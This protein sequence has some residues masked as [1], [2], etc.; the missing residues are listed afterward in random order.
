MADQWGGKRKREK[1]PMIE[2]SEAL[3]FQNISTLV[4]AMESEAWGQTSKSQK[5]EDTLESLDL[6]ASSSAIEVYQAPSLAIVPA[7]NFKFTFKELGVLSRDEVLHFVDTSRVKDDGIVTINSAMFSRGAVEGAKEYPINISV[8]GLRKLVDFPTVGECHQIVKPS[9]IE[10]AFF[11]HCGQKHKKEAWKVIAPWFS[12]NV[13][14]AQPRSEGWVVD[15]FRKF[16]LENHPHGSVLDMKVRLVIRQVLRTLGKL[17]QQYCSTTLVLLA[18]AHIDPTCAHLRPDW[19]MFVSSEIRESLNHEKIDRKSVGKFREGWAAI[20]DLVRNEFMTKQAAQSNQPLYLEAK[21]AFSD[22]KAEWD[23]EKCELVRQREE[24]KEELAKA[25]ELKAQLVDE[26]SQLHEDMKKVSTKEEQAELLQIRSQMEDSAKNTGETTEL[27][28]ELEAEEE[29]LRK[30]QEADKKIRQKLKTAKRKGKELE[31]EL[32]K[33]PA[34]VLVKPESKVMDLLKSGKK[35][36]LSYGCSQTLPTAWI[37]EFCLDREVDFDAL[38]ERYMCSWDIRSLPPNSELY[39]TEQDM[40]QITGV[41]QM[42]AQKTKWQH[43]LGKALDAKTLQS[44][45]PGKSSVRLWLFGPRHRV[46]GTQFRLWSAKKGGIQITSW[47]KI[48][49]YPSTEFWV[50][51]KPEARHDIAN[52]NRCLLAITLDTYRG[53]SLLQSLCSLNMVLCLRLRP[54][55]GLFLDCI[56]YSIV[57]IPWAAELLRS[58]VEKRFLT[59]WAT[60]R[61]PLEALQSPSSYKY[62]AAHQVLAPLFASSKVWRCE[63]GAGPSSSEAPEADHECLEAPELPADSSFWLAIRP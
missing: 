49:E 15:D 43:A 41:P 34:G 5:T 29:K 54:W 35:W 61:I 57:R 44:L 20:I 50:F 33:I 23:N 12:F 7:V 25:Q 60:G 1:S 36:Q 59:L 13:N 62:D 24:L 6:T 17:S 32:K 39:D 16:T 30:L 10:K 58:L 55:D 38:E 37:H 47:S 52:H 27:K 18:V 2:T 28:L 4:Q 46:P 21:N 63:H 40:L 56:A 19:H 42:R 22:T 11:D 45:T 31:G 9:V 3:A 8:E 51:S 14:N 48:W 26:V 53:E